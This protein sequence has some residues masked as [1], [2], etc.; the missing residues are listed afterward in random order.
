MYLLLCVF[1]WDSV[2]LC[3][4]ICLCMRVICFCVCMKVCKRERERERECVCVGFSVC[5]PIC[6]MRVYMS[7]F[8]YVCKI[9]SCERRLL[10]K[11]SF[12]RVSVIDFLW[13][14]SR[15]EF[16]ELLPN[17]FLLAKT[18]SDPNFRKNSRKFAQ[19]IAKKHK[20]RVGM[21]LLPKIRV[22]TKKWR[23]TRLVSTR[24]NSSQ[25]ENRLEISSSSS[26]CRALVQEYACVCDRERKKEREWMIRHK[27]SS[28][29][30]ILWL[31]MS[32]WMWRVPSVIHN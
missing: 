12:L 18:R 8:V 26:E 23:S 28:R 17:S 29:G 11:F 9:G 5:L 19:K 2:S 22:G 3:V 14:S 30:T 15:D 4:R 13:N 10:P 31:L 1:V 21:S 16:F 24:E 7:V 20:K 32:D 27:E 25:L 6:F